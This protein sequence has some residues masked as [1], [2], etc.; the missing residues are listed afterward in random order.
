MTRAHTHTPNPPNTGYHMNLQQ[1]R[2]SLS[3]AFAAKLT[4]MSGLTVWAELGH[5]SSDES[6]ASQNPCAFFF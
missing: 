3:S 5:I 6:R 4:L 1:S 2:F